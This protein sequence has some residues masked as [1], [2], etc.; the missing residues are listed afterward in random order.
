[1]MIEWKHKAGFLFLVLLLSTVGS[2]SYGPGT[3][4]IQTAESSTP[5]QRMN[6]SM[7][8]SDH[9]QPVPTGRAMDDPTLRYWAE[10]TG[11]DLAVE[12]LPHD[13]YNSR[14]KIKF[15]GGSIPDVVQD[16][17]VNPDLYAGRKL[18]PLNDL[19]DRY[20]LNLKRAIPRE[21]WEAVTI[22]GQIFGI[23]EAAQ[24]NASSARVIYV[25]KDW[26]D[27][28]GI[29]EAPKTPDEYL[30]MLR[31]FRD[32]DPNGNGKHDE[33][34]FSS[35]SDLNWSENLMGMF[36][37]TPSGNH[38]V[39]GT[40]I[41]DIIHPQMKNAIAFFRIMVEEKLI[42][43]DFLSQQRNEWEMKIQ[44]DLVGSWNHVTEFAW[45]WQNR[46]NHSLP[47]KGAEVIAIPTPRAPGVQQ[48]GLEMNAVKKVFNITT[49]ARNPETIVKMFDWLVSD[50]GQEFVNFGI[51]GVTYQKVKGQVH[52]DK[53]EDMASHTAGWRVMLL[54]LAGYNK[55]LLTVKLGSE[56]VAKLDAAY[57]IARKEGI[58]NPLTG[59]PALKSELE[60]PNLGRY[61][62]MFVQSAA[63]IMLG[64]E[65][66]DYFDDFVENWME[67][68]G[69]EIVKEMTEWY[70]ANK[71]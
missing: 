10:Q 62:S 16:W 36:G 31:A 70:R 49:S 47:G 7:L 2:C 45:E 51:P 55:E 30:N 27:K 48:A 19:L 38:L 24:G 60:Y 13:T 67:Q 66:L 39:G 8:M 14:M 28:V 69:N 11:V 29:R 53:D 25:R 64:D 52:Y 12:W 15:V 58:P 9:S 20:G 26:M 59:I 17:R 71:M 41:P 5:V 68:G 3:P 61:R 23:P 32:K 6:V 50:E 46:L 34:P 33:I 42:D 21:A 43:S 56:A 4:A 18:I 63:K 35:R 1:M 44:S 57:A 65:P 54:N 37:V 22:D 40:I